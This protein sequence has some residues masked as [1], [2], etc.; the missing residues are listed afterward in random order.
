[1]TILVSINSY[2]Q[3]DTTMFVYS[4]IISVDSVNKS[5][6]YNRA[7]EW[8]AKSYNSSKDVLQIQDKEAGKLVGKASMK[9]YITWMGSP[10]HAGYVNYTISVYVKEGKYKYEIDNVYHEGI[11]GVY[12]S[13]GD[14][15]NAKVPSSKAKDRH[16]Q[17]IRIG[18]DKEI[19]R[20]IADLKNT[21]HDDYKASDW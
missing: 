20:I 15:R 18:A 16:W 9:S 2:G 5:D 11:P 4:G 8:F 19:K 14:I 3:T 1:M 21:M 12:Y 13:C 17:E 7:L 10:Y 6:L